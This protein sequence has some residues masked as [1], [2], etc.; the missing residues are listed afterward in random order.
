MSPQ[1]KLILEYMERGRKLTPLIA[2]V[3]LGVASLT[4]RIA[5]L[6]HAGYAIQGTWEVDNFNRRYMSYVL[7]KS[8]LAGTKADLIIPDD[9][10]GFPVH[11]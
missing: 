9:V 8:K 5:E 4:S 10:E 11:E 7:E 6:R 3:T 1:A 2:H